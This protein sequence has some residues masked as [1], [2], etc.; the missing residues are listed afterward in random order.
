MLEALYPGRIDLGIGRAPGTDPLT[1]YALR[2]NK[3]AIHSHDFPE[4]LSELM[5]FAS[6]SFPDDHPFRAITAMPNDV[7]FPSLWLL[8][9]S[10]FSSQLAA[11]LGLGFAFAHHINPENALAALQG[12]R[13]QFRP[14]AYLDRPY[15]ILTVA[16]ICAETTELAERLASSVALAIVRLRNGQPLPFP[17]PEE[18]LAY[19]YTPAERAQATAYRNSTQIVGD[20]ASV[21]SQLDRL[22]EKTGADEAMVA[23]LIHSHEARVRSYE[24]LAEVYG[25]EPVA[26]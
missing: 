6:N 10:T 16:L 25:L 19:P 7:G 17:S 9:S 8:G 18:A 22:V 21:R 14:S 2:R 5:A 24:L 1:A 26:A 13:S 15:A 23:T 3:D 11:S 4:H 12:Y 20:P